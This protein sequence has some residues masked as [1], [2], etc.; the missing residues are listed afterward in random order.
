LSL[1][2]LHIL[3]NSSYVDS[4]SFYLPMHPTTH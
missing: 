2:T 1:C 3:P 4:F